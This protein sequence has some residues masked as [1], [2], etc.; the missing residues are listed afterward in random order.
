MTPKLDDIREVLFRDQFKLDKFTGV[1]FLSIGEK[2][3]DPS[4]KFMKRFANSKIPVRKCFCQQLWVFYRRNLS[5]KKR[6]PRGTIY[7]I[8]PISV[9]FR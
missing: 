5:T 6:A 1:H 3:T 7:F 2:P 9:D 4:N 8:H